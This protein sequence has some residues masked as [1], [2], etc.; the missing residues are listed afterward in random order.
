MGRL[1]DISAE[2]VSVPDTLADSE[3]D[4]SVKS[5]IRNAKKKK[6]E[7]DAEPDAE[8]KSAQIKAPETPMAAH[9][10]SP[11][12]TASSDEPAAEE[13][14]G[15]K[16]KGK[17]KEKKDKDDSDAAA[18]GIEPE[19]REFPRQLI[20]YIVAVII[21]LVFVVLKLYDSV[22]WQEDV[23]TYII[24]FI[25]IAIGCSVS[26]IT[27]YVTYKRAASKVIKANTYYLDVTF[28]NNKNAKNQ[29]IQALISSAE[30]DAEKTEVMLEKLL[31]KCSVPLEY[32]SIYTI[33]GGNA[34]KNEG[35]V[36]KAIE[37]YEKAIARE[38]GFAG[39]WYGLAVAHMRLDDLRPA[40]DELTRARELGYDRSK[41]RRAL[42]VI[43]EMFDDDTRVFGVGSGYSTALAG[44]IDD[45]T[46]SDAIT[47]VMDF[48]SPENPEDAAQLANEIAPFTA[49]E[50]DGKFFASLNT[51]L[52]YKSEIFAKREADGFTGSG[53]D[54]ENLAK[55]LISEEL[56]EYDGVINFASDAG[57]F[58]AFSISKGALQHFISAFAAICKNDDKMTDLLSRTMP[59]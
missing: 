33:M 2:E 22:G 40:Q 59:A 16:G 34:A 54:W 24:A 6:A 9:V 29:L 19:H 38:A 15:K 12:F 35:D 42:E 37:F 44:D 4:Q 28:T 49:Y 11:I 51:S 17:R 30:G 56:Q 27:G 14:N 7:A 21:I 57:T 18:Q 39:A 8:P 5:P 55:I 31:D 3:I 53:Y 46:N 32:A 25:F 36:Q 50:R 48:A 58:S 23:P 52:K 26:P 45:E 13:E 1:E 47:P 41:V 20:I 10:K 43:D